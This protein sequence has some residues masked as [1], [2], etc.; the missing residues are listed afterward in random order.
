MSRLAR[1]SKWVVAGALALGAASA[2]AGRVTLYEG[3]D[4]QGRYVMTNDSVAIVGSPAFASAASSMV[5]SDGIWEA[6]TDA[7]FRGRC[8]RLLPGTYPRLNVDLNG[9]VAS[10]RQV[11]YA[12]GAARAVDPQPVVVNPP[13]VVVNPA[14]IVVNPPQV[15]VNPAPAVSNTNSVPAA[16]GPSTAIVVNEQPVA[17]AAPSIVTVAPPAAGR[18]VLY[19]YPNFGG[20]G[21]VIDRGQAKDL[22]WANFAYGHRAT[23][24]RVESGTW[25]F[26]AE[27]TFQGECRIFGPG[28]YPQLSG[29]LV[30]G[31]SSAQQVRRPEYG[32]L[33]VYRR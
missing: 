31:I 3:Q 20:A 24:V 22:D 23:S 8:V 12:S 1:R 16:I 10:V 28:E 5:V 18:A 27:M 19:E 25:M 7:Y 6:C 21:V 9:R 26:C 11:A 4:F 17:V 2:F 30:A 32:A 15:V 14:P 33:N 13:Q 29:P